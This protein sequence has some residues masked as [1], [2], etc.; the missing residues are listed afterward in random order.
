MCV[1]ALG[2][3]LEEARRYAREV[4]THAGHIPHASLVGSPCP[5]SR[6]KILV[7]CSLYHVKGEPRLFFFEY[8]LDVAPSL[9][10]AR[11]F[12]PRPC[13]PLAFVDPSSPNAPMG[14]FLL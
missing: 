13:S 8:L 9:M 5:I 2:F 7:L 12:F 3:A 4:H 14:G 11:F 6:V 1:F 10:A